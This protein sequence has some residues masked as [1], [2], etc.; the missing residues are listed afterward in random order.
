MNLAYLFFLLSLLVCLPACS[1][2]FSKHDVIGSEALAKDTAFFASIGMAAGGVIGRVRPAFGYPKT[3]TR[4]ALI[5]GG[6]AATISLFLSPELSA[7]HA[8]NKYDAVLKEPLTAEYLDYHS[9]SLV[10]EWFAQWRLRYGGTPGAIFTAKDTLTYLTQKLTEADNLLNRAAQNRIFVRSFHFD[11][12]IKKLRD[13]SKATR[14]K[15][16][17]AEEYLVASPEWKQATKV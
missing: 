9:C 10:K 1:M 8:Q 5:T 17:E 11:Q 15:V 7:L 3:V 2:E 6:L 13:S 12:Q 14:Q 16:N 4:C